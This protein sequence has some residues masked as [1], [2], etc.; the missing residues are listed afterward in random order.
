MKDSSMYRV[1]VLG[2]KRTGQSVLRFY[3]PQVEAQEVLLAGYA[4]VIPD[5]ERAQLAQAFPLVFFYSGNLSEVLLNN[6][7]DLVV[8]S[9]GFSLYRTEL[10]AFIHRGGK[11]T[12]DIQ[13]WLEH[14]KKPR[15]K[16]LAITGSNG[17][18]TVT[19]LMS[20]FCRQSG[21]KTVTA[22]NIGL[23][24]LDV[25]NL[26]RDSVDVWVLELSSFQLETIEHLAADVAVCLNVSDDHLDRYKDRLDYTQH[27]AKIF[28]GA[29]IQVLNWDDPMCRAMQRKECR[30]KWFSAREKTDYWIS[31]QDGLTLM[32]RD[33][34]M[35]SMGEVCLQGQHNA[36]NIL[37]AL[38]LGS[39]LGIQHTTML[40]V[41]PFFRGL[42]HRTQKIG[43]LNAVDF[44]DDS[45]ATNVAA[46]VAALEGAPGRVFLIA[47]G[48]GKDQDFTLLKNTVEERVD[49]LFLIGKA[50][51]LIA[52]LFVDSRIRPIFCN[53]LPEATKRAYEASTPG[54]WVLLSPACA[55]TD[56][57]RDYAHRSEIF[58]KTFRELSSRES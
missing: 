2:L 14:I 48:E 37:A 12:G 29:K 28:N 24:V 8:L 5:E 19:E 40:E 4:E 27:K 7:F 22:G 39:S 1:L 3:Q 33:E 6:T 49:G 21:L 55:S 43:S 44:I 36:L 38:G 41:L 51:Q 58:A 32:H 54:S 16:V 45:K 15:E 31:S 13:L 26:V 50:A 20:F 23:P 53:S 25:R 47:G 56:M 42:A 11:I 17:K 10:Q 18:S 46:T 35:I 52:E 57:F 30:T 9:P 34:P